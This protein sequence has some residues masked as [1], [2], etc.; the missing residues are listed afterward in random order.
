MV[1]GGRSS[2][3][4]TSKAWLEWHGSTLLQRTVGVLGRVL[5]GPLVVVRAPGQALPALPPGTE[6]LDD[7][8]PDRGPLPAI[9]VG[10]GHVAERSPA[11]FVV[12]V[13]LPLLHPAFVARVLDALDAA[14]DVAL[15]V[16]RGHHQPLAAA[17]RTSLA[18]LIDELV[19]AGI[20]RPPSLFERARVRRLDEA[21]LLDDPG[22]AALDPELA[23]LT[24]V[25][26]PEEYADA[27]ARPA[28]EVLLRGPDGS[29]RTVRAA[30]LAE[31]L[32]AAPDTGTGGAGTPPPD[33]HR[34]L[35]AGDELELRPGPAR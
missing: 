9:G 30:T 21:A 24:N 23:S 17:Y 8:V 12:S 31:A 2:R 15:P 19:E 26:T 7:P 6:V 32:A 28:P 27:R 22:L 34:P 35:V 16:A 11:A 10:L 5:D 4:G 13:D 18:G 3:M 25:N 1:A 20:G 29:A 33:P 14:H